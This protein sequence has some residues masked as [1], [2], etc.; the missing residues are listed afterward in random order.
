MS[1]LYLP[2]E[3]ERW[4]SAK[5][6]AYPVGLGMVEG[7]DNNGVQ[8][9]TIPM[10]Y[11]TDIWLRHIKELVG[12]QKF[13]QIWIEV[14]HSIIPTHILEWLASL[15]PIRVGFIVESLT[16]APEEFKDNFIGTQRRV[17]NLNSKLPYL[18]HV[19]VCDGRDI[20]TLNIPAMLYTPSIPKRLIKI[21]CSTNDKPIFYG[22]PYGNRTE[23]LNAI[24][25]KSH[26]NPPSAEDCSN[27]PPLF[28]SL[29]LE[30]YQPADYSTFFKRWYYVRQSL[31]TLWINYLHTLDG[32]AM[33]NLPHRTEMAS[34]RI[35][36]N[37]AAGKPV[38]SPFLNNELT[39]TF[40]D[41]KNILYYKDIDGLIDCID[42]LQ[43]DSDLRFNIAEA[44]RL[45]LLENYTTERQIRQ[46]L[47]FT[48]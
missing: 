4:H 47:E 45:N 10:L 14:V 1:V 6:L 27:L 31:Y 15:A 28:E 23:W 11:N 32:C 17:L 7:L 8:H 39:S 22:T 48:K 30:C 13:D 40:E 26:I 46:I 25:T 3:F 12:D 24:Q 41:G 42:R 2:L 44:A 38:I 16:I 21:P 19:V 36:E 43:K 33:I 34:G 35:I 18:T 20:S 9:L 29:F 37:M 5:K